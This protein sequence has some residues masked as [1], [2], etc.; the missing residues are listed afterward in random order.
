MKALKTKRMAEVTKD[1][2]W[3]RPPAEEFDPA[4]Y[5]VTRVKDEN[6]RLYFEQQGVKRSRLKDIVEFF[7]N[8]RWEW[9]NTKTSARVQARRLTPDMIGIQ[10]YDGRNKL[11]YYVSHLPESMC[12]LA[13][14][15]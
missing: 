6:L 15:N 11:T 2:F 13:R 12:N 3:S 5:P 7:R 4:F 8:A 1:M 9:K 14:R 10:Y